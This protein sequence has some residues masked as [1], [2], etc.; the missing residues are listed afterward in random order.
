MNTVKVDK[1]TKNTKPINEPPGHQT[2]SY[3]GSVKG[4]VFLLAGTCVGAG[5]LGLPVATAAAGFYPTLGIFLL[6]CSIM[7]FTALVLL[8]VSLLLKGETNLISMAQATLGI[9]GKHVAWG[10]SLLFLYSIMAAYTLGGT[11]ILSQILNIN[12]K[13]KLT[14]FLLMALVFILPFAVL[15]YLGTKWVD[16]VNGKLVLGLF[17]TF[18]IICMIVVTYHM[19]TNKNL[20]LHLFSNPKYLL[21]SMPLIVTS[22]GCHLLIPT[23]KTHLNEDIRKLRLAIIIGNIIPLII[24]IIWEYVILSQIPAWGNNGLIHMLHQDGNP[25]DLLIKALSKNNTTLSLL[26]TLFSLFALSSSFVGVA[27]GLFD[28]LAD[29]LNI[30][31]TIKGKYL[32]AMLTFLPPIVYAVIYPGGFLLALSY[33][34]IFASILLIIYP[35]LMAWHSRYRNKMENRY[36]VSGGKVGLGLAILFGGLVILL[37]ICEQFSLLPIPAISD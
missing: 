35:A 5:M 31:K 3:T 9:L 29:G 17:A 20:H 33:A 22:F 36:Q 19:D 24:Y 10:T 26:I 11:T 27:L 30:N 14:G 12:I 6:T 4:G 18:I 13:D 1:Y 32:L 21:M 8:E 25:G 7:T 2:N 28:F 15:V 37:E 23:L 16:Y 34:G